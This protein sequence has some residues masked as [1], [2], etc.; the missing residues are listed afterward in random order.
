MA[1][2]P[3]ITHTLPCCYDLRV[4]ELRKGGQVSDRPIEMEMEKHAPPLDVKQELS[5]DDDYIGWE[6]RHKPG[7]RGDDCVK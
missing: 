5:N 7:L 2:F 4:Q 3:H 6:V 1:A